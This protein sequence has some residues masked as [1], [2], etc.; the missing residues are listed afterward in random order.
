MRGVP[1]LTFAEHKARLSCRRFVNGDALPAG[2]VLAP[3]DDHR[4][5]CNLAQHLRG[6]FDRGDCR[7]RVGIA[8]CAQRRQCG[9]RERTTRAEQ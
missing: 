5:R 2:L 3:G 9:D 8:E 1:A 6:H 7:G 4:D